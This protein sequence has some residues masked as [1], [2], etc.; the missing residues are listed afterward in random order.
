MDFKGSYQLRG[1]DSWCHTDVLGLFRSLPLVAGL[2]LDHKAQARE[3]MVVVVVNGLC[4]PSSSL[5][6]VLF[7]MFLLLTSQ[8]LDDS[9][10]LC[11]VPLYTW[12]CGLP[13]SVL[14]FEGTALF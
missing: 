9:S 12:G 4:R 1:P 8:L 11:Q 3:A 10:H 7:V 13:C 14:D 2:W 5:D 6:S